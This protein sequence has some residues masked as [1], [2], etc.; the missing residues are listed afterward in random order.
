MIEDLFIALT[1]VIVILV[2]GA[3]GVLIIAKKIL[4]DKD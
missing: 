2:V 4:N 1:Q 3:I